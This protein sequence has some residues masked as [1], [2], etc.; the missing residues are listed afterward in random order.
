MELRGCV[1]TLAVGGLIA[2][3]AMTDGG[4]GAMLGTA[5]AAES[6]EK[7]RL[8]LLDVCVYDQWKKRDVKDKIV[9]DCKCAAE[10]AAEQFS[11]DQVGKFDGKLTAG[12]MPLWK[13]AFEI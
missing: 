9:D 11:D 6:R 13:E 5:A 2:G 12:V 4:I 3:I 8:Q 7:V 1:R 10:S